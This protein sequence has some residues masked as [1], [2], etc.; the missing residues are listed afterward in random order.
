MKGQLTRWPADRL[1]TALDL[2][3]QA[4]IDSKTTGLPAEEICGRAVLQITRA[5]GR[6][7]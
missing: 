5:A 6:R 4:E 2:L 3:L 1:A 7:G